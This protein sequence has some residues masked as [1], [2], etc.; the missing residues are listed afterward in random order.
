MPHIHEK[1]DFTTVRS[2]RFSGL[3][4]TINMH[5]LRNALSALETMIRHVPILSFLFEKKPAVAKYLIAGSLST[6][7]QLGGLYFLVLLHLHYLV[8]TSLAFIAALIVS[9]TLHKF[10]TFGDHSLER[11]P[12]QFISHAALG[13]TNLFINGVL[14]YIF[15]ENLLHPTFGD[16]LMPHWYVAAQALTSLLIALESFF[17]YRLFI[18]GYLRRSAREPEL[19]V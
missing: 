9:F 11:V 12:V 10:W 13:I 14:M 18:F 6:A 8:A 19:H 1:I 15:V 5:T 4:R 16:P 2:R 17:V 7:T 3:A